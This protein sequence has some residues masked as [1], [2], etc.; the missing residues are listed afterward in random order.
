MEDSELVLI[1]VIEEMCAAKDVRLR[2][3]RVARDI[4]NTEV[5]TLTLDD[6]VGRCLRVME[7]RGVRHV[8]VVDVPD[9]A[10][11]KA[12]FVGIV[13]QRDV[14]RL[15]A[16]DG[17]ENGKQ[18][19]DE[20][21]LRQLLVQIVARRPKSV[22]LET[23]VEEIIATMTSNHI[24]MVPVLDDSSLVGIITT[25]DLMWLLLRL[26][27]VVRQLC[28]ASKEG[29]ST[30]DKFC[31][32]SAKGKVLFS[33]VYQS[34]EE[35]MTEPV[36]CLGPGDN[37]GRA[38][39]VLQTEEFRHVPIT[40]EDGRFVGLVSDRDILRN[41]PFAGRRPPSAP[42]RF[43]EHLFATDSRSKSLEL[44][45]ESIMVREVSRVLPSCRVTD[46]AEI[47]NKNKIS[48]LL[49]VDEQE[50]LRG[51][52]TVTDLMRALAGVYEPG[53]RAGLTPSESSVC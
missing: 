22:S 41:L 20:R 26:D 49:V 31:E 25:S 45:L 1:D 24:D 15:S 2:A 44:T 42:K 11:K 51:I 12:R 4:M 23:P 36:I 38:I 48:C 29:A 50:A 53:E 10:G 27:K 43:R 6:R 33:W 47:L 21:A 7:S 46:A 9:E 19:M 8:P 37:V 3:M 35:I 39:E 34:V 16:Q 5:G 14:L 32:S 40:D 52:V 28:P 30:A 13:S 17:K 18:K